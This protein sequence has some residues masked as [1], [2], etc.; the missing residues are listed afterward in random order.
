MGKV[1]STIQAK[2]KLPPKSKS[3]RNAIV[4]RAPDGVPARLPGM[5]GVFNRSS[6]PVEIAARA[7][8]GVAE[9]DVF[10]VIGDWGLRAEDFKRVLDT[11]NEPLIRVKIN[12]PGGDV[13]D[14]VAIHNLL[15]QHA[16]EIEVHVIGLAASAASVIAMAGDRVVMGDGSFLMIHN[17]W[18]TAMGDTRL[19][20]QIADVLGKIDIQLA[21][22]Y[23][24]RTGIDGDDVSE[25]MN[26]ETWL[27]ADDAIE[28]GFAD[29]TEAE[30]A[31]DGAKAHDLS[32]YR[33]VPRALLPAATKNKKAKKAKPAAT[34][35]P[36]PDVSP[37]L[38]ELFSAHIKG[39]M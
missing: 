4:A 7:A 3:S 30:S 13:F 31:A 25:M 21:G 15:K 23:S 17:A 26:A 24:K 22:I 16:S 11:V 35:A 5:S 1:Q 33:N 19:M 38:A 39:V 27:S 20:A 34:E 10:G 2:A 9:I 14:G 18:T 6:E 12:S 28:Y 32:V 36:S 37:L 29:E 8:A